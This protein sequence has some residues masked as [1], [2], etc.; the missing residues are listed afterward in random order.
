MTYYKSGLNWKLCFNIA[1][2]Y[3]FKVSLEITPLDIDILCPV[4]PS[5][6]PK[7][8]VCFYKKAAEKHRYVI[9]PIHITKL[10]FLNYISVLISPTKFHR[11]DRGTSLIVKSKGF[12][13]ALPRFSAENAE[14]EIT[15]DMESWHR[16]T[17]NC[18]C[19]SVSDTWRV[20]GD[21]TWGNPTK[22]WTKWG[23]FF[24]SDDLPQGDVE[25][26][27][28]VSELS[29]LTTKVRAAVGLHSLKLLVKILQF[30]VM[31]TLQG[32]ALKPTNL[33]I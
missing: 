10:I 7:L 20:N 1:L 4:M 28:K 15:T 3:Y 29:H 30:A 26:M 9:W 13:M 33:C 23:H 32:H 8:C 11:E 14:M 19:L 12:S 5:A 22:T 27:L 6:F 25:K 31:D 21:S 17:Q 16:V 2:L 24:I 18:P